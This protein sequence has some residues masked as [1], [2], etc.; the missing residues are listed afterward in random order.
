MSLKGHRH[1]LQTTPLYTRLIWAM[2]VTYRGPAGAH[3]QQIRHDR[4]FALKSWQA[5]CVQFNLE[6]VNFESKFY[7]H[8]VKRTFGICVPKSVKIRLNLLELFRENWRRFF[9]PDSCRSVVEAVTMYTQPSVS[10]S[11][12]LSLWVVINNNIIA[13]KIPLQPEHQQSTY[14][15]SELYTAVHKKA[16][17]YFR[18]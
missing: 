6:K 10:L 11:L 18:L 12:S 15:V 2:H 1:E 16:P 14:S 7:T 4:R 3:S 9:F 17:L 8:L 13:H 5:S